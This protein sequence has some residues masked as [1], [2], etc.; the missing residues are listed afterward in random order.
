MVIA[1]R[2]S[3]ELTGWQQLSLCVQSLPW[4]MVIGVIFD[5]NSGIIRAR[6]RDKWT[7]LLDAG[8]GVLA[9]V[10]TFFGALVLLDGQMHPLLLFS[11]LIGFLLEHYTFGRLLLSLLTRIWRCFGWVKRVCHSGFWRFFEKILKFFGLFS[12]NT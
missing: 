8:F 1:M 3:L 11:I 10:I 2:G 5:V 12:K 4:G 6:N 9:A 7:V